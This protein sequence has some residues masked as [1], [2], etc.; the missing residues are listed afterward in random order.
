MKIRFCVVLAL[1][2]IG[3]TLSSGFQTAK[4][5]NESNAGAKC[6]IPPFQ[7]AYQ[8]AQAVFVGEVVGEEKTGDVRAFDF[9]VEKYWKGAGAKRVEI[10]VY[11]TARFQAWFKKG[12]KYLIYAFAGEDD[13]L[14]VG[15]CSRSRDIE[16]AE[17]DLQKLGKGNIPR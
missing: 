2:V 16:F 5:A 4:S 6:A 13:E 17:D 3:L 11:E 8:Q 7:Q 14:R 9:R 15:R 1:F 12:G 10:R